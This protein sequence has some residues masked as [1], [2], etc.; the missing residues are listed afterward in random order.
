VYQDLIWCIWIAIRY[1][2]TCPECLHTTTRLVLV[3]YTESHADPAQPY[4]FY[5]AK[6]TRVTRTSKPDK[7]DT[8][9]LQAAPGLPLFI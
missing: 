4:E 5:K 1:R 2:G 8:T 6:V 3:E 7:T 9:V